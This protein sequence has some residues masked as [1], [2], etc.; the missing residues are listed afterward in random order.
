MN[1]IANIILKNKMKILPMQKKA[2]L[3]YLLFFLPSSFQVQQS[4]QTI[5]YSFR[6]SEFLNAYQTQHCFPQLGFLISPT[7]YNHPTP[8]TISGEFYKF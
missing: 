6:S 4:K 8:S 5:H 2:K 1:E 7:R 3:K